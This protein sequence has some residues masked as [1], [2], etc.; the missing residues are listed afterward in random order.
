MK[1]NMCCIAA[2]IMLLCCTNGFAQRIATALISKI[3]KN[4]IEN[5]LLSENANFGKATLPDQWK[6]ES[7]VLLEHK[8]VLEFDKKDAT[9]GNRIGRGLMGVLFAIPTL[10]YSLYASQ[11]NLKN[12]INV[13]ERERRR[14]A[15]NDKFAVEQYGFVYFRAA[16]NDG[17][18]VRVEKKDGSIEKVPFTDAVKVA[19]YGEVPSAYTG[20]TDTRASTV[21]LP[22]YYK[23]AV[24]NLEVG[25][26]IDYEFFHINSIRYYGSVNYKEFE[27]VYYLCNGAMPVVKQ[28]IE[29]ITDNKNYLGYRAMRGAGAFTSTAEGDKKVYRWEDGNREKRKDTRY[30]NEFL[31]LPAI[32][33]Q[34]ISASD[35]RSEF[36]WFKDEAAATGAVTADELGKR[37]EK[38]WFESYKLSG[39]GGGMGSDFYKETVNDFVKK[40]RSSGAFDARE[41]DYIRTCYYLVRSKTAYDNWPD[42]AFAKV[43]SL[44]LQRRE[45]AH[46]VV[47]TTSN[48]RTSIA[49]IAFNTEIVWGIRIKGLYYFNPYDHFNPTEVVSF[50]S[51]NNAV[52]F[53]AETSKEKPTMESVVLPA[54]DTLTAK[55]LT[56]LEVRIDTGL[57]TLS[58]KKQ[59]DADGINKEAIMDMVLAETNYIETDH[60]N[61][62]GAGMWENVPD[63][64]LEKLQ[65]EWSKMKKG[66]RETKPIQ[67]KAIAEVD[68]GE[69][70]KDYT[71][72]KLVQDGRSFKKQTLK[73]QEEFSFDELVSKAGDDLVVSLPL[74]IGRQTKLTK[75]ERSRTAAINFNNPK[76][77][78]WEIKMVV[79]AG[80]QVEGIEDLNKAVVND[81][82]AFTCEANLVGNVVS[83]KVVKQYKA[84][85]LEPS[86][87]PGV[88][89]FLDLAYKFSQSKIVFVKIKS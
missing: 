89:Q 63:Q 82:G 15:L 68:Y 39:G 5:K 17:F 10:G 70:V 29:V 78:Q 34:V 24:S 32:K 6:S 23:L 57:T 65:E 60:K 28:S 45:I 81:A 51:G 86:A 88:M 7:A 36:V 83:L 61:Y 33:F 35:K 64:R 25:D 26:V 76:T 87:W 80:Y 30:L 75:E 19:D 16:E 40:M 18:A 71:S 58:I 77:Y 85:F 4:A 46:E 31:E 67:M 72:F 74:L 53:A 55:T 43:F 21:Y 12:Y 11:V 41:D 22:P 37:A 69:D 66:W 47:V 52:V 42:Y 2:A 44:L 62:N 73:Y 50:L 49:D 56:K 38:Y 20:Y 13:D 14:V 3:E 48:N 27:P 79:P 54:G 1:K 59:V 9:V 84:K 8:T